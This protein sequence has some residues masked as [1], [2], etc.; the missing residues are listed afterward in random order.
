[1]CPGSPSDHPSNPSNAAVAASATS[2]NGRFCLA[3]TLLA[4]LLVLTGCGGGNDEQDAATDEATPD[5]TLRP[6]DR[7]KALQAPAASAAS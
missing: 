2:I 1:M 6:P 7:A 3:A 5:V 4:A